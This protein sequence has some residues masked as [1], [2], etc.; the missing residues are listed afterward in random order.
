MVET[1]IKAI[2]T[3]NLHD[4]SLGGFDRNHF[5]DI[6]IIIESRESSK[7]IVNSWKNT[8]KPL[9]EVSDGLF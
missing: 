6:H 7:E 4:N 1:T 5:Q 9:F 8:I 3:H 2:K